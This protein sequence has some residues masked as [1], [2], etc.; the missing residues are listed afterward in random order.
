MNLICMVSRRKFGVQTGALTLALGE[1]LRPQNALYKPN[2]TLKIL[3]V[4]SVW[5]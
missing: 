2:K 4:G 1:L 3:S 5:L